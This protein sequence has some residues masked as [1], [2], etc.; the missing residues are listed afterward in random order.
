MRLRSGRGLGCA[1]VLRWSSIRYQISGNFPPGYVVVCSGLL[2]LVKGERPSRSFCKY[3]LLYLSRATPIRFQDTH[4]FTAFFLIGSPFF[5]RLMIALDLV[6]PV[7]F[8]QTDSHTYESAWRSHD[9]HF[10]YSKS[11]RHLLFTIMAENTFFICTTILV[12]FFRP[13][14]RGLF[15]IVRMFYEL[16]LKGED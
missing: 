14:Q 16:W 3:C 11:K 4:D 8:Q 10:S 7:C 13:E 5:G 9:P 2:L 15:L 6:R 12:H 1:K